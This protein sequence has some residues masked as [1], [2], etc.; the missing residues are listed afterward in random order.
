[1][2][3]APDTDDAV[4]YATNA[5]YYELLRRADQNAL[6]VYDLG[7]SNVV[8]TDREECHRWTFSNQRNSRRC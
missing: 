5:D 4:D 2:I 8:T 6:T 1:M 3:S 7:T